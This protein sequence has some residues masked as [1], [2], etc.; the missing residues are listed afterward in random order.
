MLLD[1][2]QLFVEINGYLY[3]IISTLRIIKAYRH[4]LSSSNPAQYLDGGLEVPEQVPFQYPRGTW[5]S[6]PCGDEINY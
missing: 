2:C 3:Y 4:V 6:P 5:P 1:M